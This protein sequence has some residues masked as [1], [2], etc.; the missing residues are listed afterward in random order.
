MTQ[1]CVKKPCCLDN[2]FPM[3]LVNIGSG[4][5]ILA[6]YSKDNYKRVTG[7]RLVGADE[8]EMFIRFLTSRAFFRLFF[9]TQNGAA[10][11]WTILGLFNRGALEMSDCIRQCW[12]VKLQQDYYI[13]F[14][15]WWGCFFFCCLAVWF[16]FFL[17]FLVAVMVCP[18]H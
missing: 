5:S 2:P 14:F 3:L 1:N 18:R 9:H 17:L 8:P 4:V 16:I 13:I 7:T 6:V 10:R 12:A 11:C 15:S